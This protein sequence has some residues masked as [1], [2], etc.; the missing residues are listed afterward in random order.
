M[1]VD[2]S[3]FSQRSGDSTAKSVTQLPVCYHTLSV[4]LSVT[5]HG[6]AHTHNLST[7][8]QLTNNYGVLYQTKSGNTNTQLTAR[9]AHFV[10]L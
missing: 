8:V 2:P 5:S 7:T 6:N 4:T 9:A 3:R 1:A 10:L